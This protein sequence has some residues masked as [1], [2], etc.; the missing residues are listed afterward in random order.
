[1]KTVLEG[2]GYTVLTAID[3]E[4]AVEICKLHQGQIGLVVSDMGL[5]KFSGYVDELLENL[6]QTLLAF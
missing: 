6:H 1:V 4:E 5:P 2:K 3:G